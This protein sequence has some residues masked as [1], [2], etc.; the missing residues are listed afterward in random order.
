MSQFIR[1]RRN[2]CAY[3][4]IM[5][6]YTYTK[7]VWK[8]FIRNFGFLMLMMLMMITEIDEFNQMKLLL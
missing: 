8:N 1:Q 6:E 2:M 5:R 4:C 7:Y 3:T